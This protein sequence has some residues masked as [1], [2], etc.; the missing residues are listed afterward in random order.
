M[1]RLNSDISAVNSYLAT[2]LYVE[3]TKGSFE[4][5]ATNAGFKARYKSLY[6]NQ[7]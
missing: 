1:L 3:D 6:L 7:S 5:L 4:K 2:Q